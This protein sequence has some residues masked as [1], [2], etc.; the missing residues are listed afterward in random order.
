MQFSIIIL[1]AAVN[2]CKNASI[3][4]VDVLNLI[5]FAVAQVGLLAAENQKKTERHLEYDKNAANSAKQYLV[6]LSNGFKRRREVHL[7]F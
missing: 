3:F 1:A 5:S 2:S 4:V 6:L 7:Y